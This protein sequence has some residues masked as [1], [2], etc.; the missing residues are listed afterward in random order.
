MTLVCQIILKNVL[1]DTMNH[2]IT[3]TNLLNYAQ[4]RTYHTTIIHNTARGSALTLSSNTETQHK[5]NVQTML[6]SLAVIDKADIGIVNS[7]SSESDYIRQILFQNDVNITGSALDSSDKHWQLV[8]NFQN[9]DLITHA[10]LILKN[11]T[12]IKSNPI[13]GRVLTFIASNFVDDF[14]AK[15]EEIIDAFI[16]SVN[17]QK[18]NLRTMIDLFVI[19]LPLLLSGIIVLLSVIIWKQYIKEKR[20]LLAFLKLNPKLVQQVLDNLKAFQSQLINLEEREDELKLNSVYKVDRNAQFTSSHHKGDG[21][22]VIRSGNMQRRYYGYNIKVL[23][24]IAIL[25][26]IVIANYVYTKKATDTI[27]KQQGQLQYANEISTI[28]AVTYIA[29]VESFATNN[30]NHVKRKNPLKVWKEGIQQVASI[31]QNLYD[32]FKQE[33]GEYDPDVAAVLFNDVSCDNF[34]VSAYD[35]CVRLLSFGES[36]KMTSTLTLFKNMLDI[37]L[38][39]YNAVNKTSLGTMITEAFVNYYYLLAPGRVATASAQ[40]ISRVINEKL[41]KSVDEL[42]D[43]GTTILIIFSITLL[44]VSVLIWFQIL[45]KVK[46]VNN[47]FKKVLAVLPPNIILSSFLLKSFLNKTSNIALKL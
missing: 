1:D 32:E 2:L 46:E 26:V 33:D 6:E 44:V 11:L 42:Y 23:F 9:V 21:R 38:S 19:I 41:G 8:T 17:N 43:L 14:L 39:A 5:R 36:T 45:T 7:L 34:I 12:T 31:Q 3:K 10:A 35:L 20:L 16:E 25:I 29:E 24:Y 28:V 30:T 47:D 13:A 27:Y 4:L 22:K 15:N 40:L 37:K 18:S